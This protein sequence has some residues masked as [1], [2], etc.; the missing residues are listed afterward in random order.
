M[1]QDREYGVPNPK[2]PP[3]LSQFAFIIG[4]WSCDL[5][6]KTQDGAWQSFHAT[7]IG[8]YILDGYVISDEYRMTNQKGE[9]VVHGMNFRSYSVER[10]GW[11]MR[12]VNHL[13]SSWMEL[14]PENLGGV[15][16]TPETI[17][18]KYVDGDGPGVVTRVTFSNITQGH[19]TWT[20]DISKDQE[21]TWSDYMVIECHRDK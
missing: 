4:K 12:W 11:V 18:F 3:E 17:T 16:V 6:L 13:N 1:N 21:K 14:G 7:W 20:A 15:Q 8:R 2:A 10:K 19:F 9:L 5:K